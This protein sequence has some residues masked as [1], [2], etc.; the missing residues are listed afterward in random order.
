MSRYLAVLLLLFLLSVSDGKSQTALEFDGADD[1]VQ[2]TFTGISGTSPR[3]FM[4]WIYLSDFP[5]TNI[6]IADYGMGAA[7]S[8]NTFAVNSNGYL[9]YFSGGTNANM[10]ATVTTVPIGSWV[11]VV[12]VYNGTTGYFYQ[13]GELVG[14]GVL[15]GVNTLTGGENFKIGQRVSGGSIPFKGK[16][17]E[18]SVWD[19]ALTPQEIFDNTCIGDPS[20]YDNLVAYYNFNEGSG[21]TL[22]DLVEGNDGTLLNMDEEDW[23]VSD[24]CAPSYQAISFSTIPNHLR[25]DPP[26]IIQAY[27]TSGLDVLFEIISGPATVEGNT[28]TLTGEIG[29]VVV[30]ATQPG[31][32]TFDPAQPV[33]N[34]FLVLEA[35]QIEYPKVQLF[36]QFTSSSCNPCAYYNENIE[37]LLANEDNQ[38]KYSLIRY[39]M[40]WP[41][42]GDPYFTEEGDTRRAYYSVNAIP[43]VRRNGFSDGSSN[44]FLVSQDSFDQGVSEKTY[45]TLDALGYYENNNVTIDTKISANLYESSDMVAHIVVFENTTYDNATT[46]GETEFH[47]VM[48]KMLPDATGTSLD[49][50]SYQAPVF[51]TESHDMS[52]TFV[53]EMDDLGVVVFVQNN[54]TKEVEQSIM[55]P[56]YHVEN[57]HNVSVI[58]TDENNNALPDATVEISAYTKTTSEEGMAAFNLFD[59]SYSYKVTHPSCEIMEGTFEVDGEDLEIN[60]SLLLTG[61]STPETLNIELFPN[62]AYDNIIINSPAVINDLKIYNQMGQLVKQVNANSKRLDLNVSDFEGGVYYV[63]VITA[64]QMV[65]KKLMIK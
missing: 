60:V 58:V 31:N 8:R 16:I 37:S 42:D 4:A 1:Y 17:D 5:S 55:L 11:H 24:V 40:D 33:Q 34:S 29:E 3:T 23:A 54:V 52:T 50:I 28:I 51:I 65:T 43:M 26:F 2:T 30:E 18:L 41:S 64:D 61:I 21:T 32:D 27:A 19:A 36:E 15:T 63:K 56:I 9:A 59:G 10:S 39:Q 14:T 62:P 35:W 44:G 48:M 46:N 25:I 47:N 20:Q 38:G 12:F 7:G 53:E 13:N 57:V 49:G 22:T 6:C 45:I